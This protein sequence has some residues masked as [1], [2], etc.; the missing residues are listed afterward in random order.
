MLEYRYDRSNNCWAYRV[1]YEE[2][3]I[4]GG[5]SYSEVLWTDITCIHNAD[6]F[7]PTDSTQIGIVDEIISLDEFGGM[8]YLENTVGSVG[9][10]CV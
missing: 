2:V 8:D 9:E 1:E 4:G 6:E 10:E 5:S 7:F 3:T